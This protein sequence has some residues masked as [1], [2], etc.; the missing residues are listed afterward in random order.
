MLKPLA[1]DG[2]EGPLRIV[3]RRVDQRSRPGEVE[4][5]APTTGP[6]VRLNGQRRTRQRQSPEIER[7]RHETVRRGVDQVTRGC[8]ARAIAFDEILDRPRSQ[9]DHTDAARTTDYAAD[10][11]RGL[12]IRQELRP[13]MLLSGQRVRSGEL[14]RLAAFGRNRPEAVAISWAE[15]YHIIG[16]P[17]RTEV[18][19]VDD[20]HQR[21]ASERHFLHLSVS[22]E[23][24]PP[25][26]GREE[27]HRGILSA[28]DRPR[29][30]AIE[31][32]KVQPASIG[33]HSDVYEPGA[34]RGDGDEAPPGLA[35]LLARR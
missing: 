2:H 27:R 31:R 9:R 15:E 24:N 8:I 35:Q 19:P 34:V 21:P 4:A 25:A 6:E 3:T 7:R 12:S 10:E 17:A 16:A 28:G 18:R 32:T 29:L 1:I 22:G 13:E 30:E 11:Q 14:L 26:I 33:T 20:R 23:S 5:P